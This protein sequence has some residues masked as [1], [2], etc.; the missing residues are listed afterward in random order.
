[1]DILSPE[2]RSALMSRI[3]SKDT[4]IEVLVRKG[5]HRLGFRYRLGGAG[6]PGRPDVVLPKYNTVIFIHG[7]F[8]HGHNCKLFRMPKTRTEFW[9]AKIKANLARD[10]SNIKAAAALGWKPLVIWECQL[11]RQK[12]QD[13]ARSL[14]KLANLIRRS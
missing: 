5:L 2:R 11:R 10:A 13:V 8:W 7:C 4:G 1:M 14:D 12:A 3:R 9:R 6:L